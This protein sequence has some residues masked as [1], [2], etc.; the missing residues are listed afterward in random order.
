[1]YCS[2]CLPL[3]TLFLKNLT[4][5]GSLNPVLLLFSSVR[6]SWTLL[7]SLH[8]SDRMYKWKYILTLTLIFYFLFYIPETYGLYMKIIV[9]YKFFMNLCKTK[10]FGATSLGTFLEGRNLQ[11]TFVSSKVTWFDTC[12]MRLSICSI[13]EKAPWCDEKNTLKVCSEIFWTSRLCPFCP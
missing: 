8:D 9:F 7:L 11:M 12:S 6:Q 4:L 2:M 5:S 3:S 1:M 10:F 13:L